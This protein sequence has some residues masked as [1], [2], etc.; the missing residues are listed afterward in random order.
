MS[1]EMMMP[2]QAGPDNPPPLSEQAEARARLAALQALANFEPCF[3]PRSG[4]P[5][6][7]AARMTCVCQWRAGEADSVRDLPFAEVRAATDGFSELCVLGGGGGAAC[8]VYQG[9]LYGLL[10]AVKVLVV[11]RA[12]TPAAQAAKAS[13]VAAYEAEVRSL[14][15]LSHPNIC[16]LYAF[17]VDGP[18]RCLVLELCAGG[19]L[20]MRLEAVGPGSSAKPPLAWRARVRIAAQVIHQ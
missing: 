4:A 10:V 16:S 3:D 15:S 19:A 9:L 13:A 7:T 1:Q 20:D 14:C 5:V 12:D 8:L 17:S 6:N 2:G 18:Q 11:G